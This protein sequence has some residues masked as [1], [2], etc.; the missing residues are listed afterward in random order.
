MAC[1]RRRVARLVRADHLPPR[2][3]REA[4]GGRARRRE[5]PG[6]QSARLY[7]SARKAQTSARGARRT[8]VSCVPW[9][10]TPGRRASARARPCARRRRAARSA[11]ASG[12]PATFSTQKW[13]SASAAICGRC[14][15]VITCARS[16]EPLEDAA[17]GVRGLAADAGVD[18]VEDERLAAGDRR[19]RERDA[20]ELAARRGL[21]DRAERQAR[22][23]ADEE[24]RLVATG[25][26]G[27]ALAQLAD[28]LA[29]AHADVVQLGG[30]GVGER[31][32]G[33]VPLGA[34]LE[35]ERVRRAPRP[36]RAPARP[37][38]PGSAPSSSAAS[39]AAP[40]R[41]ARAAPRRSG[42][43]SGASP[44][45]CGRALPR[46]PRGGPARPRARRGTSAAR[47]R[48]RAGAARRRAARRRRA[49]SSG[50]EAL[51][52]RDRALGEPDEAR[53]AFA[54]LRRERLC[55]GGRR[56]GEL[57]DVAEPLALVAEP[58]LVARPRGLR[59]PRR[60]RAA[61]RGAPRRAL[62]SRSAPRGGGAPRA[63]RATR[64]ARRR[65]GGAARRRRTGRAPR[66]G[67]P[68]ARGAAARTARTSRSRARRRR[69]RPRGPLRAPMR[70]RACG[71]RRRRGARR[72]A[73]PRPP[74]AA[75]A[76][77]S[78]SSGQI[79]LGLDVGLFAGGADER[80]VALR[81]RAGG[82][83]PARGS[84]CPRRSRR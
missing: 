25:R 64:R 16:D 70:R 29:V 60:A 53:G 26:A 20:G 47:T 48:S 30:D 19:D 80:L 52:R 9:Q 4:R 14:V 12:R 59:C 76:S 17:D 63:A 46:A 41:R 62:R 49:A 3:G 83:P 79:E 35:R 27:L 7:G 28:E 33:G 42:S 40:R 5:T 74:G 24:D 22:V 8:P 13:R 54:L 6:H 38:A 56:L 55:G 61:R 78:S 75:R 84:S 82:R 72:A 58:L 10:G 32:R 15:I 23:R 1:G 77:S 44:R 57:G 2:A 18:L 11:C 31:R 21:G 43:G 71:R 36:P 73:R 45:R 50:R 69:R 68:A 39:S 37:P 66:A 34:E 51:E 65:G 81:R 67:T